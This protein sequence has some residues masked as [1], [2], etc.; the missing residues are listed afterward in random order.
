MPAIEGGKYVLVGG[1]SLV[2]SHV[3]EQLLAGGAREV[4]LLDN[5][6]LGSLHNIE[7]LLSTG[8]CSFVRGD[9]L[10]LNA[11]Y[12]AFEAADG[13]FSI[14]GFLGQLVAAD[15]W[16][17]LDVNI[18]GLQNVLEA[19]RYRRVNKVVFSSSVG[20]YGEIGAEPN[21]EEAP[22]RWQNMAP[23]RALYAAS[24]I[25]GE[26]LCRLYQDRHALSFLA[27]RYSAVYGERQHTRAF[28][29]T[30]MVHAYDRVRSG[31]PPIIEGDG[32]T[33]Q[34]YV[35]AGDV[36]RAN[37]MAMASTASG[38]AMNIVS[39]VDTS[40][41]RIAEL[42]ARACGSALTPEFK[43]SGKLWAPPSLHQGFARDRAR[44][45]IGW[46]P[47]VTIEEGIRRLVAWLDQERA[48]APGDA[49]CQA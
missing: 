46:E 14:A 4:V 1:A 32:A 26:G 28:D 3:A 27:L 17:G 29:A 21:S 39:G 13:V 12:D 22:L 40:Q 16:T 43:P 36:G 24:K 49:R 15:P 9:V 44:R 48:R 25:M 11:L 7:A 37:V 33:V 8:R 45:L 20:V 38:H 6:A 31:Q 2:G 19:A 47:Q 34:D 41:A 30:R 35:Y 5:L 18:R 10:R 23:G 42:V